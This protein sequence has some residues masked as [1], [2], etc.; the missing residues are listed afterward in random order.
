MFPE[1]ERRLGLQALELEIRI[2]NVRD[3]TAIA[4]RVVDAFGLKEENYDARLTVKFA[5]RLDDG[6]KEDIL[7]QLERE[8]IYLGELKEE[9]FSSFEER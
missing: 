5:L 8:N 7:A 6:D 1:M 3:A 9:N 4:R 2:D